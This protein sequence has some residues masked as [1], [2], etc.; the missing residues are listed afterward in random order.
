MNGK[1]YIGKD[2]NNNPNY[3][4]SGKILRLAIKKHGKENFKKEIIEHCESE[5]HMSERERYWIE[6][7]DSNNRLVGYNLT[8]GGDGGDTFTH[9]PEEDKIKYREYQ[10]NKMKTSP[11][12]LGSIMLGKG[13]HITEILP[14]IADTYWVAYRAGM[15]RLHDRRRAGILTEKEKM[16]LARLREHWN[17]PAVR[18][19][20]SK[21]A[22]GKNNTTWTGYAY[23][24]DTD[25]NLVKRFECISYLRREYPL[26]FE[27][28]K[29]IRAGETD[30]TIKSSRKRKLAY[31]GYF[32]RISKLDYINTL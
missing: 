23:L 21:N 15:K 29:Q 24:Y 7:F 20:R 32:I 26:S 8:C 2:K 5:E 16:G 6:H 22:T 1:I 31:E 25:M 17:S 27:N 11:S 3:F 9:R 30:I 19:T 18:L 28:D 13:K 14:D 12:G 10:S 4:G